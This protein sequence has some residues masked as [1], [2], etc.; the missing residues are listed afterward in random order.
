[1]NIRGSIK[2]GDFSTTWATISFFRSTLLHVVS[3]MLCKLCNCNYWRWSKLKP[4]RCV[5]V[6]KAAPRVASKSTWRY[7][8]SIT[9]S[10]KSF[11]IYVLQ[12][13]RSGCSLPPTHHCSFISTHRMCHLSIIRKWI[14]RACRYV[15]YI[16]LVC[17]PLSTVH[18][19]FDTTFQVIGCHHTDRFFL[20]FFV[21]GPLLVY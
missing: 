4:S 7:K 14:I 2:A 20:L 15:S 9:L 10:S 3:Y 6:C 5:W 17:W 19:M 21:P 11:T 13:G 8:I 1:M 18:C 16:I 12:R